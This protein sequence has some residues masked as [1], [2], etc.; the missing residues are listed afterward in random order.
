MK[1]RPRR[2]TIAA[3][4]L[5]AGVIAVLVVAHWGTVCDHLEA[6]RFQ[7]STETETIEPRAWPGLERPNLLNER[8][9]HLLSDLSGMPVVVQAATDPAFG[10]W[11]LLSTEGILEALRE[12]GWRVLEQRF[13]RRAY[14]VIRN[15]TAVPRAIDDGWRQNMLDEI[16]PRWETDG[17]GAESAGH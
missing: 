16:R 5:G 11:L 1:R 13:P 2:V 14:V 3:A 8:Y 17:A 6:W 10:L 9:I 12:N 15:P 7:L 4:V